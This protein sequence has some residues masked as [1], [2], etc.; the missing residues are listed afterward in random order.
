[1]TLQ[2]WNTIKAVSKAKS[3]S[4]IPPWKVSKL[5]SSQAQRENT[6]GTHKSDAGPHEHIFPDFFKYGVRF[7]PDP[8]EHNIYRTITISGLPI[9]MTISTLLEKVRG[10]LVVDAKLLNIKEIAGSKTALITFF[11]EHSALAYEEYAESHPRLFNNS[12]VE[13]KTLST[14]TW[15]LS[16]SLRKAI[17]EHKHTRCLEVYNFP[18]HISQ[19]KFR[20]D[21][22][23]CPQMN[24]DRIEYMAQR[25][26]GVLELR[27][28][29]ID[30][31][32][33]GFA[34]FT[35]FRGY[36]R[37]KAIF[38]QDPC[39]MPLET[40]DQGLDGQAKVSK[41]VCLEPKYVPTEEETG[42]LVKVEWE[43]EPKVSRG[44]GV[45]VEQ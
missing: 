6:I 36:K 41:E 22:R 16:V 24:G 40:L 29:S 44:R 11:H 4:K 34:M 1:M 21:I 9:D 18:K 12:S 27:F 2:Q 33:Q 28:S 10:G 17:E 3:A 39:A 30:Y 45:E 19:E 26:D 5:F 37:C 13:V 32:G 43:S 38:V 8:S 15:P 42:R 7:D 14:P 35:C 25:E 31:A 23:V 20:N